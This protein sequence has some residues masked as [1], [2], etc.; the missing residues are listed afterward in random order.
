MDRRITHYARATA[1]TLCLLISAPAMAI[2][3][4][5]DNPRYGTRVGHVSM[6][7]LW[8]RFKDNV[9]YVWDARTLL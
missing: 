4:L 1:M 7:D 8:D 3:D 2:H 9:A 6:A 5:L